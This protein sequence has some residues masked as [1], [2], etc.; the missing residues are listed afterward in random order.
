MRMISVNPNW[1]SAA[2]LAAIGVLAA[3]L[4]EVAFRRRDLAGE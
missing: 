4:G 1:T 2:A 3:V